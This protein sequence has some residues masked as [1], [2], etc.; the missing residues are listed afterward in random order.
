MN[1]IRKSD[2][3]SWMW[4]AAI[5]FSI[6]FVVGRVLAGLIITQSW[7]ALGFIAWILIATV[8]IS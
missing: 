1:V 2:I 4:M 7:F 8:L 5:A 6:V 3:G